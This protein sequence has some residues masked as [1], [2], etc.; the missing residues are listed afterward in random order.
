MEE[1]GMTIGT[2]LETSSRV[3]EEDSPEEE[4]PLAK[5]LTRVPLLKG[6]ECQ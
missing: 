5:S 6:P 1:K 2:N 4:D 3:T